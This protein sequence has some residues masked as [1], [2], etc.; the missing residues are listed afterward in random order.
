M[1]FDVPLKYIHI[2]LSKKA[3]GTSFVLASCYSQIP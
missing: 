1:P 2:S 3:V